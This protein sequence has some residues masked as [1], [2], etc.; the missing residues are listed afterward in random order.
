[1]VANTHKKKR[2]VYILYA[3]SDSAMGSNEHAFLSLYMHAFMHANSKEIQE[4]SPKK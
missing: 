3:H 1:M 2:S 4:I